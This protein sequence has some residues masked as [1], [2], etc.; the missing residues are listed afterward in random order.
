M[1]FLNNF[2]RKV[3]IEKGFILLNK[4]PAH[5]FGT[6]YWERFWQIKKSVNWPQKDQFGNFSTISC[7]KSNLKGLPYYE[8]ICR[9]MYLRPHKTG[10]FGQMGVSA[11]RPKLDQTQL[12]GLQ[13][14]LDF[15]HLF[16]LILCWKMVQ[17]LKKVFAFCWRILII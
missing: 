14:N 1:K 10:C 17:K 11:N 16:Y 7:T 15:G 5:L 2:L 6:P 12:T 3:K 4:L 13:T 9:L 8:K